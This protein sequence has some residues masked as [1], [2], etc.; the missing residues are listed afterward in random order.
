MLR[1]ITGLRVSFRD[2]E[3]SASTD[4]S[5]PQ[6]ADVVVLGRR[7]KVAA[8][9]LCK[10]GA[11]LPSGERV[12]FFPHSRGHSARI[13]FS[14]FSP[15]GILWQGDGHHE[16]L[17]RRSAKAF[18]NPQLSSA[19]DDLLFISKNRTGREGKRLSL[20]AVDVP[21]L[22]AHYG[23]AVVLLRAICGG[24]ILLK[25]VPLLHGFRTTAPAPALEAYK[26]PEGLFE[27]VEPMAV[28]DV[29]HGLELHIGQGV[30]RL[31]PLY[32]E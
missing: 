30:M 6:S 11:S 24:A 27:S 1:D 9:S 7:A 28:A 17:C 4:F 10:S 8:W 16:E 13:A 2:K 12:E 32:E 25:A 31:S 23:A 5:W 14:R 15:A 20:M 19:I 22:P 21:H 29:G 26:H 18:C 3:K